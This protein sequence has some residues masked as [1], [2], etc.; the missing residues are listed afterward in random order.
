LLTQRA[1]NGAMRELGI[2]GILVAGA[3]LVP[4]RP[5]S[6]TTPR[7]RVVSLRPVKARPVV[8]R[9]RVAPVDVTLLRRSIRSTWHQAHDD[10]RITFRKEIMEDAIA[11]GDHPAAE[12]LGDVAI[13]PTPVNGT[14]ALRLVH[15]DGRRESLTQF[16]ATG[17]VTVVEVDVRLPRGR[18]VLQVIPPG[19][20]K[21]T[22]ELAIVR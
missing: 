22:E 9:D 3:L 6:A 12:L 15:P 11:R 16:E 5:V 21:P 20:K 18:S 10:M 17:P 7:Q 1:R 8:R 4:A 19:Q 14:H 2:L 13:L